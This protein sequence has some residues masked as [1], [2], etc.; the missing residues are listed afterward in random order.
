MKL[1]DTQIA[2]ALY[3]IAT[4]AFGG[5]WLLLLFMPPNADTLGT[6]RLTFSPSFSNQFFFIML[7]AAVI[8]PLVV[9]LGLLFGR[10]KSKPQLFA[11]L[12][13]GSGL[14][15]AAACAFKLQQALFLAAPLWWVFRAY[16]AAQPVAQKGRTEDSA[17]FS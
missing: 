12:A 5:I 7:A 6:L 16:K 4:F 9:S 8:L 3:L 1:S 15:L 11:V 17:R 10:I 2:G 14:A 13:V